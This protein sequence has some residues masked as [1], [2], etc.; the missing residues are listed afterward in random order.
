VGSCSGIVYALDAGSG[1]EVWTYDTSRDGPP[2]QFHGDAVV[3]DELVVVGSDNQ[4]LGYLYAFDRKTGAVRWKHGFPWGVST[5]VLRRGDA[6]FA[7]SAKGEVVS[8]GLDRGE[9]RWRVVPADER[10][11]LERPVDPILVGDRLVVGWP[12]GVVDAF[13]LATGERVWRRELDAPVATSLV[14]TPGG[15]A[16]GTAAGSLVEVSPEGETVKSRRLGTRLYGDLVAAGDCLL[17]LGWRAKEGHFVACVT[18]SL[19]DVRW[20]YTGP[21]KWST[22]RPLAH[23]GRVLV[24]VDESLVVLGLEDGS[25]VRTCP[26]DG[27]PRGLGAE[28]QT[29]YV[30]TVQGR[31]HAFPAGGYPVGPLPASASSGVSDPDP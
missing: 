28:G 30:G 5:Q 23:R 29:L 2:G 25:L 24:G 10:A 27:T 4:G 15:L 31:L 21:E 16:V 14:K 1:D 9:I 13:D 11:E 6:V 19:Q 18:P 17:T 22:L 20:S 8:V 26:M 7:A 3:T 12:A